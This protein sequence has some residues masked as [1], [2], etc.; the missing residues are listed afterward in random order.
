MQELKRISPPDL[1]GRVAVV[2]G[3]G[4]GI[5]H[6]VARQLS[7]A[8]A[9]VFAGIKSAG[10]GK[11]KGA[12][13][14]AMDVT[15]GRQVEAAFRHISLEAGRLD[16][17]VNNAGEIAPIG[18]FQDLNIEDI[19]TTIDV[20]FLG[21]ARC[22]RAALPLLEESRGVIVNA[23]TGAAK[24]PLEGWTAYCCS[25]SAE[26]MLSRMIDEEFRPKGVRVFDMGIPPSDTQLQALVRKSGINRISKIPR[27]DLVD[28]D[29]PASALVWL[30]GDEARRID[31]AVLDLR[32]DLFRGLMADRGFPADGGAKAQA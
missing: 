4:Q 1:A 18:R 16:I 26:L 27:K 24:I 14:L 22:I 31:D 23:G 8:G 17:L 29:I 11:V 20:N 7:E 6:S 21:A 5:G 13:T 25:K 19:G 2:T 30:C 28:P 3:A 12:E 10:E 9:T 15:D 32:D